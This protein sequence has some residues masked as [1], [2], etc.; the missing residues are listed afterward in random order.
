MGENV[1]EITYAIKLL[2]QERDLQEEMKTRTDINTCNYK[3]QEDQ[4]TGYKTI[5]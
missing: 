2:L 1:N 5:R 3:T 4:G